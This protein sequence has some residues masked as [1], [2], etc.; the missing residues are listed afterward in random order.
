MAYI[1]YTYYK[2]L[3]GELALEEADFNR[4]VWEVC[5]KLDNETSGV[6]GVKKLKIAFPEDEEDSEAVK[7]CICKMIEIANNIETARNRVQEAQG[8]VLRD[9]G[10]L[11][12]KVV[13]SVSAGNESISFSSN[14]SS[15]N[16]TLID[17]ALAD[18]TVEKKLYTDTV[19]EYLSGV[20]DANGVNLL[21]MGAYPYRTT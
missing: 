12:G 15:T 5:K 11:Q 14:G 1:D 2:S 20:T 8:Y 21:Y 7:R 18:S 9:D 17:K 3:Y 4:F 19:S 13:T 6:D 16:A 10:S